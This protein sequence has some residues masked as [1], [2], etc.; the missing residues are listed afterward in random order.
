MEESRTYIK[1]GEMIFLALFRLFFHSPPPFVIR[2]VRIP[3]SSLRSTARRR[4]RRRR[5]SNN[6]FSLFALVQVGACVGCRLH[7]RHATTR[8]E[9]METRLLCLPRGIAAAEKLHTFWLLSIINVYVQHL[10]GKK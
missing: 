6:H 9:A 7:A 10:R 1:K 8:A 3:P 5:R 4:I 2:R